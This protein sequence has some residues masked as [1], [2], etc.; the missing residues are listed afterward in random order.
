VLGPVLAAA[1]HPVL[2]AA[3]D[4][5]VLYLFL[6]FFHSIGQPW[7]LFEVTYQL[8]MECWTCGTY[9]NFATRETVFLVSD[10]SVVE[11]YCETCSVAVVKE[12]KKG[13]YP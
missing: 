12:N 3:A 6:P 9:G 11:R 2:R 5:T 4:G 13:F 8:I 1:D 7:P 10:I